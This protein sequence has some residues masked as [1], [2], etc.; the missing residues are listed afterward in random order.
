[1]QVSWLGYFATT[2]MPEMDYLLADEVGV[3][4]DQR[5]QFTES[6]WYLPDTR[7][8][9]TAPRAEIPVA[10]LPAMSNN[11]ITFGCFQNLSKL[12]DD[13]LAAWGEI[14][15][16]LPSAKLRIQCNQLGDQTQAAVLIKRLQHYCIDPS[17]VV[18]LGAVSREDY[19]AAHA[20]VDLILDT[21]PYPGGTTTCEALWMGVPTLTL[22]GKNLLAR[23]GASLLTAAGLTEWIAGNREEYV[24]KAI[25][26]ASD[27]HMLASLRAGLRQQV[28]ASP[29]FNAKR[30][31]RNL[32]S[33]LWDMWQVH[34]QSN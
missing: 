32:E 7:L 14:F 13:V 28:L 27:L 3:P 4:E 9:F 10:P 18:L 19:L 17:R 2:G 16:A 33:A 20:E 31:A 21:F 26:L 12:G 11:V 24:N 8:C 23:Q 6:V 25:S 5:E 34:C 15:A 1:V 30:F 22:T 29:V